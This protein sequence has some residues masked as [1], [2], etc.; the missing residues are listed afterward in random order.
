MKSM[1]GFASG[2]VDAEGFKA[3]LQIKAYNNRYLEL[4]VFLPQALQAL[5]PAVRELVASRV[6]RGKL[7]LSIRVREMDAVSSIAV[8]RKNAKAVADA[9]REL[10][11]AAGMDEPVRLSNLLAVEGIITYDRAVDTDRVWKSLEPGIVECLDRFDEAREREGAAASDDISRQLGVV[12]AA[13][14]AVEAESEG[15]EAAIRDDLKKRFKEVLGSYLDETRILSETAAYL[16]KHTI[17]EEIVRLRA[18][19]SAFRSA[20]R[21]SATGKKLDFISQELNR[22]ANTIGS[23]A[24]FAEISAAVISMKDA[25]ENIREQ[26]RNVE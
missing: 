13:V 21:E 26:V 15:L 16:A 11:I 3:A 7:E 18:H 5:E 6:V 1:T 9:L 24:A 12:G 17:N 2:K 19:L 4:A 23:K 20:M 25:I 14:D 22:E 10:S 8:D